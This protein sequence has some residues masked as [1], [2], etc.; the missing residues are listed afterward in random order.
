L[1][2]RRDECLQLAEENGQRNTAQWIRENFV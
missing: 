1:P 2:W